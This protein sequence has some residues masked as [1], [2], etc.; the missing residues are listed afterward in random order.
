MKIVNHMLTGDGGQP[1]AFK[2]SPNHG[3]ALTPTLIVLHD[4]AS[5][6]NSDG[7]ISWLTDPAAKVSAHLV[8]GRDGSITQLVPFDVVAWHAGKS[9]W[10]GRSGCNA[11]SVGIEIVNPGEMTLHANGKSAIGPDRKNYDLIPFNIRRAKDEHHPEAWWMDYTAEQ[12]AMITDICRALKG[13]YPIQAITTHWEIAPGRKVDTNPFFPLEYLRAHLFGGHD[14]DGAPIV[15]TIVAAVLR[16]WPSYADNVV[17]AIPV[18]ASLEP[19]RS[20]EFVNDGKTEVWTLARETS[21]LA[22]GWINNAYLSHV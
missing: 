3:G 22:E 2:R 18:G 14:D 8:V 17:T 16:R 12:I 1:I 21:T 5:G 15:T 10:R 13:A 9:S 20:G 4:T 7:P 11:F 6:L 19:L